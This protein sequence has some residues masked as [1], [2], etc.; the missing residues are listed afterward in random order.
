MNFKN[1]LMI[2]FVLCLQFVAR[3]AF[4]ALFGWCVD[5]YFGI[6]PLATVALTGF[7]GY[8]GFKALIAVRGGKYDDA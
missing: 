1:F 3:I 6:F 5:K 8:L 7:G 2:S 4:S